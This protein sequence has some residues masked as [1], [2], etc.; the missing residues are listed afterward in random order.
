MSAP[1]NAPRMDADDVAEHMRLEKQAARL[2]DHPEVAM[3]GSLVTMA[4][5]PLGTGRRRYAAWIFLRHT[6]SGWGR[7]GAASGVFFG[8]FAGP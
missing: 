3:C 2:A 5:K 8:R 1:D 6:K 7:C 4:G